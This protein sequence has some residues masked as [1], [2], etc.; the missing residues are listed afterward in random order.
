MLCGFKV[1]SSKRIRE[2]KQFKMY[3]IHVIKKLN[4]KNVYIPLI[5]WNSKFNHLLFQSILFLIEGWNTWMDSKFV[6][7]KN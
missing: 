6:Q 7:L 5:S 1:V 3:G 4:D 2:K